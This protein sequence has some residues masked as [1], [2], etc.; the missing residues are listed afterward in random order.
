M[1]L[2]NRKLRAPEAARFLGL[3]TSTLAKMRLRGD[4][5]VYAKAGRRIVIYDLA[6]LNTWVTQ[7]RRRSTSDAGEGFGDER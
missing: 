4:G 7:R 3:S 2:P 6:D 5:P 1:T